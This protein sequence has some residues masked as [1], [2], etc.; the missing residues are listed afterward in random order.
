MNVLFWYICLFFLGSM[1]QVIGGGV[2]R[3]DF[4][5][6]VLESNDLDSY[7]NSNAFYCRIQATFCIRF[8]NSL[9][10]FNCVSPNIELS[11][12][13]YAYKNDDDTYGL[14]L[15][16]TDGGSD[17]VETD[18]DF[19]G[20]FELFSKIETYNTSSGK[21]LYA[22]G[23]FRSNIQSSENTKS[24][25]IQGTTIQQSIN[26]TIYYQLICSPGFVG[27]YCNIECDT[28]ICTEPEDNNDNIP[29]ITNPIDMSIIIANISVS[30]YRII[31]CNAESED[32]EYYWLDS[33]FQP[34][35]NESILFLGLQALNKITKTTP[36]YCYAHNA[37]GF[38]YVTIYVEVVGGNRTRIEILNDF[39]EGISDEDDLDEYVLDELN[40][41]LLSV[42][43]EIYT[44][45]EHEHS[46]RL[47]AIGESGFDAGYHFSDEVYEEFHDLSS[48]YHTLVNRFTK[49]YNVL[50][51]RD[52]TMRLLNT[53]NSILKVS[54]LP[55]TTTMNQTASIAQIANQQPLNVAEASIM[56]YDSLEFIAINIA[57]NIGLYDSSTVDL[58]YES[59]SMHSKSWIKSELS[60]AP[61][62]QI[63]DS[64]SQMLEEV[65][66]P[67]ELIDQ[68]GDVNNDRF[69][70]AATIVN[71][72]DYAKFEAANRVDS[73][74]ASQVMQIVL[75]SYYVNSSQ[76]LF[77][78]P[79]KI[80]F[81]TNPLNDTLYEFA[82][83]FLNTTTLEWS[84]KDVTIGNIFNESSVD[85]Y[86]K[87]LTS[88][89]VLVSPYT[90]TYDALNY[91]ACD[92]LSYIL[93]SLSLIC[94]LLS[95]ILFIAAGKRFFKIEANIVYFN[96]CLAMF[97]N[98]ALFLSSSIFR[99]NVDL[100]KAVVFLIHYTWLALF[101]W[102]FCIGL[103]ILY[104]ITIGT[105]QK[106][107]IYPILFVIGWITPIMIPVITLIVGFDN[108][109][110]ERR[111]ICFINYSLVYAFVAP[112]YVIIFINFIILCIT[113]CRIFYAFKKTNN[114]K[115]S[116]IGKKTVITAFTLTPILG[117]PWGVTII[118]MFIRH[119]VIDYLIVVL[120]GSL[121]II[122]FFVVVLLN[123]EIQE[124]L[125][126]AR[127]KR[128]QR[129][130]KRSLIAS[131]SQT[132]LKY[133]P[134]ARTNIQSED[135]ISQ[136]SPS[137]SNSITKIPEETQ[138]IHANIQD[139]EE[140]GN[141][142]RSPPITGS[143]NS[144][145]IS[146]EFVINMEQ[147]S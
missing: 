125:C 82:C 126:K 85:C 94:L 11:V 47:A 135:N 138:E 109:I 6:L 56:A 81:N 139:G 111:E 69:S 106:R 77:S 32:V 84:T 79:I 88:F 45:I 108:Y 76:S 28:N 136:T 27:Y 122:F 97:L 37:I 104:S 36:Y 102:M 116:E 39:R 90:Y 103:L 113:L 131:N 121:G 145:S 34:V 144:S 99:F 46:N 93:G 61:R 130:T 78:T 70:I 147:L 59:I 15:D 1:D 31:N 75:P 67:I 91:L 23:Y 21:Q 2:L 128:K 44:E 9:E 42:T 72:H 123:D 7:C 55:R 115:S 127:T 74:I 141:I 17:E 65:E 18:N 60:S 26:T 89:A 19:D 101:S 25:V 71:T 20:K 129:L 4:N 29:S 57:N 100:C 110:Y 63:L 95:L 112:V 68:I 124:L 41:Y 22:S 35:S 87:H 80:S 12:S 51:Q 66:I 117:L 16:T 118:G 52:I 140:G 64:N 5:S 33:N 98:V 10:S 62:L 73:Q 50:Q 30:S 13:A 43:D 114:Y 120:T 83:V 134:R 3:F 137:P 105:M 53:A 133:R 38:V 49:Q 92:Y 14:L 48:T 146:G 40:E 143:Y 58:S 8:G 107:K 119:I 132:P 142:A 24:G 54:S 86:A 96:C